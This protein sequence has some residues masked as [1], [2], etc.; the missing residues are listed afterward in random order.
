MAVAE[1]NTRPQ[2]SII[3]ARVLHARGCGR[4]GRCCARSSP[5]GRVEAAQST[6]GPCRTSGTC[7]AAGGRV[8]DKSSLA[9]PPGVRVRSL[10]LCAMVGVAAACRWAG[11]RWGYDAGCMLD[12]DAH[13]RLACCY[14]Y[15]H[16]PRV[17]LVHRARNHRG[18]VV[19]RHP[20][21]PDCDVTGAVRVVIPEEQAYGVSLL[22]A[23]EG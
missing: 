13:H 19:N 11:R 5:G 1:P 14:E 2:L 20:V 8:C 7:G 17:P 10:C 4:P 18:G 9:P 12:I 21:V 16:Q 23:V 3:K 6:A 22:T 15:S